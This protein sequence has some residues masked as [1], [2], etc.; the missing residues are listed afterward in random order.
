MDQTI[1]SGM[2]GCV[3]CGHNYSVALNCIA[4]THPGFQEFFYGNKFK[5][6]NDQHRSLCHSGSITQDCPAS[7]QDR[8]AEG[9]KS[10]PT[11]SSIMGNMDG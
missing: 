3:V 1:K 7:V 10:W 6:E 4:P 5:E 8:E 11:G 9:Q 2:G